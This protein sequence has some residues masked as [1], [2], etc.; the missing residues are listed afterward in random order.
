MLNAI[1]DLR[2]LLHRHNDTARYHVTFAHPIVWL[3]SRTHVNSD[4]FVPLMESGTAQ[5]VAFT[6][7]KRDHFTFVFPQFRDKSSFL[8]SFLD[9]V[10]PNL[11]P[12]LYP[13]HTRFLW[14]NDTPYRLP[15]E[16]VLL[17]KRTRIEQQHLEE[18][19][20]IDEDIASNRSKFSFLHD[21]LTQTGP[22]LVDTV[23][24]FLRWLDFPNVVNVDKNNPDLPEEDL[25]VETN[26]GMLVIEVKGISGTSTDNDCSQITKIRYRRAEKRDKFD[27]YGLYVVNHQ[28]YIPPIERANPPFNETQINDATN[29]G[30]GLV[31]TFDLFN[32]FFNVAAGYVSKEEARNALFQI[33]LVSFPPSSA[34]SIPAPHEIHYK[35]Q[36]VIINLHNLEIRRGDR[37]VFL[38]DGRYDCADVLELQVDNKTVCNVSRGEVGVKLSKRIDISA[39]LWLSANRHR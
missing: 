5:I 23:E 17:D 25:Q 27:V 6:Q 33:G 39:G 8:A 34:T 13:H 18:L 31:T 10:L 19:R 3:D 15:N 7:E 1:P 11:A 37:I 20:D 38:S 26:N 4:E 12:R 21:L 2:N 14:R 36:V 28:M 32:L 9:T 29:D 24:L 35:G 22:E 16:D 30:R